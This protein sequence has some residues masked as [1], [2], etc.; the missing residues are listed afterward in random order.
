[1][2][3]IAAFDPAKFASTA[4]S[5]VWVAL[6]LGLVIFFH[7]LGH[8]AVAKWCG[9]FVE[10]F[11]IGFGPILWSFKRGDTEYALS[12]VPFGG[13]VK[14]L[15]QDDMDPS[16]LS[17][18]EIAKDQRS[19]SAKT[20]WQRMAIMSAGVIMNII[21]GLFFFAVAFQSGVEARPAQLGPVVVGKPAWKAGLQTGDV[22]TR[23][24]GRKCSDFADIM[25]G[26]ALTRGEVEI[27]GIDRHNKPFKK[28]ITPDKTDTRRMIGVAPSLDVVLGAISADK[29]TIG[30]TPSSAADPLVANDKI[31]SVSG[32]TVKS[33]A[34]LQEILV[35]KRDEELE[36]VIERRPKPE[37]GQTLEEV[38]KVKPELVTIK[39]APNRFRTT[40]LSMDIEKITS[41]EKDSPAGAAGLLAGDKIIRVDGQ[42]VGNTLNPEELP[43]YLQKKH[44]QEVEIVYTREVGGTKKEL[45]STLT[46]RNRSGW[47]DQFEIAGSPLSAPAIGVTFQITSQ[48]LKVHPKSPAAGKISPNDR[49]TAVELFLPEGTTENG[50]GT[51]FGTLK[52]EATD[53]QPNFWA[54]VLWAMQMA[55]ARH[56]R[57]TVNQADKVELEPFRDP[58]SQHFFPKRGLVLQS[59]SV[60]QKADSIGEALS[61]GADH[62]RS[63]STE[64]YLTLRNLIGGDLSPKELHGPIG[65]AGVAHQF[66]TQGISP[67]L[68]FL[69]F[70]SVNLAVLN[71]LPI[72]VLDGG[73]MVF[74]CWEAVTRK[75]PNERVL[76]AAFL[77]GIVFVG[78]LM[79]W[80]IYLDIFFH[81]SP[82][83]S[84]L[85]FWA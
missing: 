21:T 82:S 37:K 42:D 71:F 54:Q 63:N 24:N 26:V 69:G 29:C 32:Q 62:I 77:V 51:L 4:L 43:D 67:L 12:A 20:V 1:M 38:L 60:M 81:R 49:I 33:F 18:E 15:G 83:A 25:R 84:G 70:L 22:I 44:G 39:I 76:N 65:I 48:V 47:T 74:L 59:D 16:Q 36:F 28:T 2:D 23:I 10:R 7:E 58:E 85:F 8:F 80:V 35:L 61:M 73:H 68:L 56:V 57:L 41:V 46:P 3:L 55:P 9:V 66:A 13:Y 78:G 53:K 30:G 72:P 11:S 14:M 19:F 52:F 79:C 40:G 75:R 50:V 27:E 6:G 5:W 64:I 17:S 31:V 45:T 34:E